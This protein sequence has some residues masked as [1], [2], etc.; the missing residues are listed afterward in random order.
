MK[1]SA[2]NQRIMKNTMIL[3]T[4]MLLMMLIGFYTSRLVLSEL[5]AVDYG[6]YF[7]AGGIATMSAVLNGSMAGATQRWITLALGRGDN[8]FLEKVFAVGVTAQVVIAILA[9]IFCESIGLWYLSTLAVVPADRLLA[10]KY[11][12]QLSVLTLVLQVISVPFIAAISAHERMSALAYFSVVDAVFKLLVCVM[13]VVTSADKLVV[14]A[15]AM[16]LGQ[17]V[18]FLVLKIYCSANFDEA[19]FR[20]WWDARIYKDMWRLALWSLSGNVAYML[21]TQGIVLLINYFFGPAVNAAA[22][23]AAQAGNIV[24]QF[25]VNFQKAMSPQITKTYAQSQF[26]KMEDLVIRSSKFSHYLMIIVAVPLFIEAPFVLEIWLTDVPNYSVSFLRAG[27]FVS[28]AMA[29]RDPLV[30]AAM[31][32]GDLRNYQLVVISI[33]LLVC[34]ASYCFYAFGG[35]P[36]SGPLVLFATLLVATV[37]SAYMLKS[38]TRLNFIRFI[39]EVLFTAFFIT[40]LCFLAPVAFYTIADPG[41]LRAFGVGAICIVSTSLIVYT[42]GLRGREKLVLKSILENK[43]ASFFRSVRS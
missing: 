22:G 34:P 27:L 19:R 5:G 7:V 12:F 32:N 14:Y 26:S 28:M 4:R 40:A 29:I 37:A 15:V 39:R 24:N 13:L 35:H 6:L 41:W 2:S 10:V 21:Y 20:L 43:V 3:Y 16:C 31:A 42:F 38:M 8:D 36:V 17:L 11:V 9:V 1:A 25:R 23:I 33:L 30:T 18:N